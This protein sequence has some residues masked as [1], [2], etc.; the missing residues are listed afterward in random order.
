MIL[1]YVDFST[2]ML[3]SRPSRYI[4]MDVNLHFILQHHPLT[5]QL[6]SVNFS[7]LFSWLTA[8]Y[9]MLSVLTSKPCARLNNRFLQLC[10]SLKW[11]S[12]SWKL[13]SVSLPGS[14]WQLNHHDRKQQP[15]NINTVFIKEGPWQGLFSFPKIKID[16]KI[17]PDWNF[18]L[19]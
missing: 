3:Y 19:V 10:F 7:L 15:F 13:L 5:T 12:Q 4:E 6:T 18:S 9:R 17:S 16:S 14:Y 1:Y 11:G 8:F 2:G